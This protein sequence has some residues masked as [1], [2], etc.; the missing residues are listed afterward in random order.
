MV[1]YAKCSEKYKLINI[2]Q[3]LTHKNRKK[4]FETLHYRLKP[5]NEENAQYAFEKSKERQHP[6]LH[7]FVNRAPTA[8][9]NVSAVF[10]SLKCHGIS[11]FEKISRE[12]EKKPGNI[13]YT[14]QFG[15]TCAKQL[16]SVE[17]SVN[18]LEIWEDFSHQSCI[19]VKYQM[20]RPA[21]QVIRR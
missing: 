2:L 15:N 4:K 12:N 18:V 5:D 9:G 20:L 10:Q 19:S 21:E 11:M 6:D 1:V 13:Q 16:C 8:P 7:G 17:I 3:F 14:F